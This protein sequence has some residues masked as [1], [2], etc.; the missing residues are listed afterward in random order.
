MNFYD[1]DGSIYFCIISLGICDIIIE[2]IIFEV[3]VGLEGYVEFGSSEW[4]W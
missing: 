2:K 3:V 4:D 1:E